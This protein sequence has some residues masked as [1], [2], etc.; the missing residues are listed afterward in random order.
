MINPDKNHDKPITIPMKITI[1]QPVVVSSDS[2]IL[3]RRDVEK[4]EPRVTGWNGWTGLL[5]ALRVATKG[6]L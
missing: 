6:H 2:S 3:P 1:H 5:A 4:R